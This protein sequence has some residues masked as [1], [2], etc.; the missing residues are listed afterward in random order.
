MEALNEGLKWEGSWKAE[1]SVDNLVDDVP[2][3][4]ATVTIETRG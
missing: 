3:D 2:G 4:A 1:N